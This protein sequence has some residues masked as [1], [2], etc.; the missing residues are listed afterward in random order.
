MNHQRQHGIFISR[1]E[2]G[3]TYS[4]RIGM[5]RFNNY[6]IQIFKSYKN[7]IKR[8]FA[9]PRIGDA[10]PEFKAVTTRGNIH[11]PNDYKVAG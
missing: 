10:A 3:Y 8:S 6:K 11:F 9:M 1:P 7:G 2:L 4:Q 5:S